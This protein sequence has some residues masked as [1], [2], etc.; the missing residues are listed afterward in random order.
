MKALSA[1]SIAFLLS[2]ALNHDL[3]AASEDIAAVPFQFLDRNIKR[4]D[5]N[6]IMR[7]YPKCGKYSTCSSYDTAVRD[8]CLLHGFYDGWVFVIKKDA[9]VCTCRCA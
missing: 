6:D 5:Y 8:S 1:V 4:F 2:I 9:A 3:N 7:T